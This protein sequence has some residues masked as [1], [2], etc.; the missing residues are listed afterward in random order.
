MLSALLKSC[1]IPLPRA[2]SLVFGALSPRVWS[3]PFRG[4]SSRA[5]LRKQAQRGICFC[6]SSLMTLA[7]AALVRN[8]S[9]ANEPARAK[10]LGIALVRF[11]VTDL[12]K[13][14]QFYQGA[15]GLPRL[16]TPAA[17]PTSTTTVLPIGCLKSEALCF[18]ISPA[19]R[20][21]IKL[22]DT[23]EG[24]RT[25]AIG[26]FVS[27][28]RVLRDYLVSRGVHADELIHDSFQT[29]FAASD[30]EQHR[31][32]FFQSSGSYQISVAEASYPVSNWLIH[33]GFVVHN[34]PAEDYFYKDILGFRPYW[35]GGMNDDK[36]D[37]ISMQVPDGTDWIEYM[38]NVSPNADKHTLGVMNH[39]ALGVP[40]I[41]AAQQQLL[42]NGWKP[43]EEPKIGRDGKWQLNLYDPDDTRVEFMEFTPVQKPCC[44]EFTGPHPKP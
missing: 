22:G 28:A 25:D 41:H 32:L 26:F 6:F 5:C 23:H 35:H 44:S 30:P 12:K 18:F 43:S 8:A 17:N 38:L 29:Y 36:D 1:S 27:D 2:H 11:N 4:L 34:R 10:I 14:E 16:H 7:F 21:E 3:R 19:Q 13:A 31:L 40:D 42:K 20:L 33:A 37:W 24:T 9:A 39:I 15:L